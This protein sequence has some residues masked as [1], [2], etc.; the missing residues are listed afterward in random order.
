MAGHGVQ[1][2][3]DFRSLLEELIQRAEA[4]K[5][6]GTIEPPL[7]KTDL[8]DISERVNSVF[9]PIAPAD[10]KERKRSQYAVVE[11]AVRDTFNDLLVSRA[12]HR[13]KE[14]I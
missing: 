4:A 2:V 1:A 8:G 10:A 14:H 3:G 9:E 11:T 5:P 7:N 13:G 12:S 6:N